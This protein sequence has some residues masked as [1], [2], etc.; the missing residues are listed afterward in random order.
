MDR[1]ITGRTKKKEIE[2]REMKEKQWR[3][4]MEGLLLTLENRE[5]KIGRRRE[6]KTLV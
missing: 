4:A 6:R 5:K 3:G 2:R 1:L